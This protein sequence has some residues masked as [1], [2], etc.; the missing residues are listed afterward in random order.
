MTR[1]LLY[2]EIMKDT[3]IEMQ[4]QVERR[5][6]TDAVIRADLRELEQR[7]GMTSAEFLLAY[8]RG[9]L[10]DDQEFIRWSGLLRIAAK[11]GLYRPSYVLN[12]DA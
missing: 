1:P 8:N 2:T 10:G 6:L 7:H 11:V 3:P 12:R 9:K 4:W 5:Q